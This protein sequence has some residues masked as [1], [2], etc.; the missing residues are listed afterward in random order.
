MDK[1]RQKELAELKPTAEMMSEVQFWTIV[2][3][4]VD[5]ASDDED[6]YL[7]AS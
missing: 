1:Q 2:Q 4:A 5:D 7:N 6:A 3:T